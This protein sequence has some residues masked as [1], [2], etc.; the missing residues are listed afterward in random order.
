MKKVILVFRKPF[1]SS[2]SIEYL[3]HTLCT[4][5]KK[6]NRPIE[7]HTLPFY[8]QGLVNR[9]RN[10]LSLLAFKNKIVH[11][12]GDVHYAIL[13]CIFSKR[14]LTIHDVSFINRTNGLTQLVYKWFWIK[15]PVWFAHNVTTVSET[16]KKEVLKYVKV[17]NE[18]IQV[19]PDFVDT[20]FQPAFKA[21]FDSSQPRILQI[22]TS[23]NKNIERLAEALEGITCTLVIIGQL[24]DYQK[25]IL[26]KYNISFEQKQNL[27]IE[28]LYQQ[29]IKADLLSYVSLIEGFGMPI[30]EAQ[31]TGLPVVTS[32]CSSMPE[33]AGDA[34]VFVDPYSANSIREGI[35]SVIRNKENRDTLRMKGFSNVKRFS[36]QNIT[37]KYLQLYMRIDQ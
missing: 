15:L 2:F 11:I 17:N 37:E 26:A 8:S 12:T 24:S 36:L 29:Y 18:K 22:G 7:S 10:V 34:A 3:F 19:I 14:I 31:A 35:L 1:P 16:T 21:E 9:V 20:I 4:E 30:L 32:N 23:F 33:I 5:F 28:E 13:G 27:S 6:H 25:E